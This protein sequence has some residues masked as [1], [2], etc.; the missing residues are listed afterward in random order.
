VLTGERRND[1]PAIWSQAGFSGPVTA[2]EGH[3]NY[4][5]V[6]QSLTVGRE[7]PCDARVTIG[8]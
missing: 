8:P 7:Y 3:G 5:I 6:T 1:A 4:V 2:L